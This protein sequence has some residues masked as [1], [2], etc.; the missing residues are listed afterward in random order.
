MKIKPLFDPKEPINIDLYL[1]KYGVLDSEIFINASK[2]YNDSSYNYVN[3]DK[4]LKMLRKVIKKNKKSAILV[5]S[6]TDG[7][8]SG[9]LAYMF[10]ESQ[11]VKNIKTLTHKGREH[12]LTPNIMSQIDEDVEFLWIPDAGSNDWKQCNELNERGVEILI[13]DHHEFEDCEELNNNTIIINN[14]AQNQDEIFNKKGSGTL[15]TYKVISAYLGTMPKS[16]GELVAFANL[17]DVMDISTYEN[18]WFNNLLTNEEIE[19]TFIKALC[20]EF[21]KSTL[22]PERLVWDVIPKI[23][24][25]LRSDDNKTKEQLFLGF[26]NQLATINYKPLFKKLASAHRAQT[27]KTKQMVEEI[28]II[29]SPE[30]KIVIGVCESSP[31][32]GLVANKLMSTYSKPILLV[33]KKNELCSGSARSPIDFKDLCTESNFFTLAQGHQAAFGVEFLEKDTKNII[34]YFNSLDINEEVCYNVTIDITNMY[35]D[36]I[37]NLIEKF[38]GY[39]DL[40]G[41]GLDKPSFYCK[42]TFNT[43]DIAELGNGTT[44]KWNNGE[45]DFLKF[46]C[47]RTT[48]EKWGIGKDNLCTIEVIGSLE[49]NEYEGNK[50]P[51]MVVDKISFK[52]KA[53]VCFDDIW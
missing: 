20:E 12:G 2:I 34:K 24:A 49:F 47:A 6:D 37:N 32:T 14:K 38:E 10:L 19:H 26:T 40:W 39:D 30:D 33:H 7:L 52:P 45:L 29:T 18:R 23:N 3:I 22:V 15:V 25:L 48:R 31:Y 16:Y 1:E 27:N 13:T 17:A 41:T 9:A 44:I 21:V 42:M 53:E 8:C 43:K 11:G 36:E 46:Y 51:Q 35:Y 50:R 5:D 28:D 4:A